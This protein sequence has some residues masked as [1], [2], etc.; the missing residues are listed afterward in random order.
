MKNVLITGASGNLGTATVER[1]LADEYRVLI[2]VSPGKEHGFE[3]N[4]NLFSYEVD[5]TDESAA[6]NVIAKIVDEHKTIDAAVLLVGGFTAG[7]IESTDGSTIKKMFT[8]NFETAYFIARPVF[9]TMRKNKTAG[10]I[11]LI[12]SRPTL[13]PNEGKDFIAYSLSKSL[14]FKLAEFLNA[15]GYANNIVASVVV[16]GTIDTAANRKAMP[17]ANFNKWVAPEEVAKNIAFLCSDENSSL[18]EPVLKL[19]GKN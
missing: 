14:L 9:S 5:L 2:T 3:E 7:G 11:I 6:A 17:D 19:F 8:L 15:E 18:R 1:F 13:F 4:E 16:P 10:R 12:G